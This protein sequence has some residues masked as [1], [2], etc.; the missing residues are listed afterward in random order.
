[1][2]QFINTTVS[3]CELKVKC[4]LMQQNQGCKQVALLLIQFV[5]VSQMK[6]ALQDKSII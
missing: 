6:L 3:H 2:S 1:M 5:K 4:F